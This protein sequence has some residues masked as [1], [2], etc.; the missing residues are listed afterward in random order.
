[1]PPFLKRAIAYHEAGHAIIGRHLGLIVTAATIVPAP[2]SLGKV[3]FRPCGSE[4]DA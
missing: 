4:M 1:M 2:N 3:C